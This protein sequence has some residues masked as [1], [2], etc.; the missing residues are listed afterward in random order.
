MISIVPYRD[1]NFDAVILF[2]KK[3][4]APEHVLYQKELFDWQYRIEKQENASRLLMDG[5]RI[6]GFLGNIPGMYWVRGEELPGV[7]LT[8]WVIDNVYERSGLGIHLL[9]ETMKK[10][11]VTLTLGS[12]RA[13][14]PLYQKMG[15]SYLAELHR[16]I[17]PLEE[18]G[19]QKLLSQEADTREISDWTQSVFDGVLSEEKPY[20]PQNF[21]SYAALAQ[22]SVADRFQ[23][24]LRRDADFWQWR[25]AKSQGYTYHFFGDPVDQGV[26]VARLECVVDHQYGQDDICV[27]RIIEAIPREEDSRQGQ[28]HSVFVGLLRGV[29]LW[30]EHHGAVA[31]DFQSSTDFFESQFVAAGFR[32]Q[33][34]GNTVPLLSLAGRF[35]PLTFN[36]K[37]I[38]FLWRIEKGGVFSDISAHESYFVKSDCDMDRP[39]ESV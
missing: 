8:M 25:Y 11:P 26:I 23:F 33:R 18:Q 9:Q 13:V 22:K 16:W 7:A 37:P 19:Y 38:N 28:E 35:Q 21:S 36:A 17:I 39:S 3:N 6:I 27:L 10:Y 30:G 2:L 15:Y 31:A 12:A 14:V 20:H 32:R 29:L 5:D 24:S 1:D 34:E 4:W